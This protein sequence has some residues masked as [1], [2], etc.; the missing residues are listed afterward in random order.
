MQK[1]LGLKFHH[2]STAVCIMIATIYASLQ[3]S[4][5]SGDI[6]LQKTPKSVHFDP[7]IADI[8]TTK[9]DG[10]DFIGIPYALYMCMRYAEF[11]SCL[12]GAKGQQ[13]NS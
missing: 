2:T 7:G 6:I 12:T 13:L 4:K 9:Q 3:I 8:F 11:S 10:P 5:C 1:R